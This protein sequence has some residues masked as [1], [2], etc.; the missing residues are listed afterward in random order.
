LRLEFSTPR[1]LRLR[2]PYYLLFRYDLIP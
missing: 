2:R 1:E